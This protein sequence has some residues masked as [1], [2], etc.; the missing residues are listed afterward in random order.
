MVKSKRSNR[1]V[2]LRLTRRVQEAVEVVIEASAMYDASQKSADI[3]ICVVASVL[4]VD[5]SDVKQ[6]CLSQP[7]AFGSMWL[8]QK[9]ALLYSRCPC[10]LEG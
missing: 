2:L 7:C 4:G 5:V 1:C 3:A 6:A 10:K 8:T 9:E